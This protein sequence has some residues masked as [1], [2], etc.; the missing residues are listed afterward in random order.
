MSSTE[1]QVVGSLQTAVAGETY[2]LRHR[3]AAHVRPTL[4]ILASS[5][6]NCILDYPSLHN[7]GTGDLLPC[8]RRVFFLS[9]LSTGCRP[10]AGRCRV[11]D[12]SEVFLRRGWDLGIPPGTPDRLIGEMCEMIGIQVCDDLGV[13]DIRAAS[14]PPLLG[15]TSPQFKT[16]P[17]RAS[18]PSFFSRPHLL[19]LHS[20]SPPSIFHR[21]DHLFSYCP[22][23]EA[24]LS[25]FCSTSLCASPACP[26]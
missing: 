23:F 1:K 3:A 6:S 22:E 7:S 15:W 24:K 9:I 26:L 21:H 4:M 13:G 25:I 14:W 16:C 10:P 11:S 5:D 2:Q 8:T 17:G 19:L 20:L 18:L 12:A